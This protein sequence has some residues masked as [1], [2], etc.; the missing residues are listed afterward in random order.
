MSE[1][2]VQEKRNVQESRNEPDAQSALLR[3]FA[4]QQVIEKRFAAREPLRLGRRRL[5]HRL[6]LLRDNTH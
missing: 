2:G 1:E 3:R 6:G 5:A 4:S